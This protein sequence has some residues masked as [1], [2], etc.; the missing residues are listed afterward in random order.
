M[1]NRDCYKFCFGPWNISEGEDPYGPPKR[2]AAA[3]VCKLS[4]LKK[5]GFDTRMF[6]EDDATPDIDRCSVTQPRKEFEALRKKLAG[7]GVATISLGPR[8]WFEP[9]FREPVDNHRR[10]GL[11]AGA[12]FASPAFEGGSGERVGRRHGPL[13]EPPESGWG[14]KL[15]AL[16][17]GGWDGSIGRGGTFGLGERRLAREGVGG[18]GGD[19][20][21]LRVWWRLLQRWRELLE[22]V[23]ARLRPS[24]ARS[25]RM[26]CF[27]I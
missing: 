4:R 8:L 2:P 3:F 6:H 25:G 15:A 22:L 11:G 27:A 18:S 23:G 14:R 24:L 26:E 9:P 13:S 19:E 7:A 17:S 1:R 16:C 20:G 10:G 12:V 21:I 5:L